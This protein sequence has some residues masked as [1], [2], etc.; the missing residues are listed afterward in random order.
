MRLANVFS[1]LI[2]AMGLLSIGNVAWHWHWTNPSSTYIFL[3]IG[4]VSAGFQLQLPNQIGSL[5][6]NF[7]LILIGVMELSVG[8][9]ILIACTG[10][11]AQVF[12]VHNRAS[13]HGRRLIHIAST[14]LAVLVCK[15]AYDAAW[16]LDRAASDWVRLLVAGVALYAMNSFPDAILE[17][18]SQE[19]TL[20][21]VWRDTNLWAFS[22]HLGGTCLAGLYHQGSRLLGTDSPA[23]LIPVAFLF[24]CSYHSYLGRTFSQRAQT[25]SIASLHQRTIEALALAIEAKDMTAHNHLRRLQL[26]CVE[27]GTELGLKGDD[28]EAIR[29]AAV[30]H[31][32]G[33][34]AVPEHILS[35]PGKLTLEE[36]EKIKIHPLVGAEILDR[37][38]FPYPVAGLVLS[39][40]EK[41]NGGG[42]PNGLKGDSI[43]LGARI[44][45]VADCLDALVSDRPYRAAVS[46]EEAINRISAEK[47]VS[48]D[49]K[50]VEVVRKRYLELESKL[51]TQSGS[52]EDSSRQIARLGKT[53]SI[54]GGGPTPA[55]FKE[56]QAPAFLDTIAAARQEAQVQLELTQILGHS[57]K[58]DETLP[59]FASG[60]K[61]ILPFDALVVYALKDQQ[62]IPRFATGECTSVLLSRTIPLGHGLSGWVAQ[63]RKSILNGNPS[64]E[65]GAAAGE[66]HGGV[67]T[68]ALTVPL[69]GM[70]GTAGVIMACRKGT[71]NFTMDNLRVML[72]VS[73]KLGLVMENALKYEQASASANTDFLTGLPNARALQIQLVGELARVRRMGG[74]LSVLVT[75]LDGF[76]Q[77]NDRFGHAA[78]N[79]VLCEVG[80][81]LRMACRE[82]DFVARM[83]GDEFVLLLPGLE[84]EDA[85]LKIAQFNRCVI[86]ASRLACPESEV[87]LSVGHARY[88][89]DGKD[90]EQL[91]AIADQRM[92]QA[93]E[94]LK[95]RRHRG[96]PRGFE[97]DWAETTSSK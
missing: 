27:I 48:F 64:L 12:L 39:H 72:G 90:A 8:E 74:S 62:M 63:H 29:A 10:A 65:I 4:I 20:G 44:L 89:L 84:D 66:K 55:A 36:F 31:D 3:L 81:A 28:I 95:L 46:V 57:L 38:N 35:K 6:M 59:G 17:A 94:L 41:W 53:L 22:Y 87:S 49:P 88:P 47:G 92:Y 7:I 52:L 83:G 33:K 67:L 18:M 58:L 30:L 79:A 25:E 19:K 60:L 93:K 2:V 96:I 78:G 45:A 68:S 91:L 86:E 32:I 21:A 77:V 16:L 13:F 51:A 54:A 76:K 26:Y 43:P 85:Q 69:A 23:L 73:A 42:Y 82:Y 1:I 5:S 70:Q 71:E 14:A 97:F 9:T 80:K 56:S 34:L 37:V 50:V 24:Y 40:H 15:S 75:D 11:A 61:R